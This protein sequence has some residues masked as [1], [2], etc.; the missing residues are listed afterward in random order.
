MRDRF[1]WFDVALWILAGLMLVP[2]LVETAQAVM[3][4]LEQVG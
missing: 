1:S 3:R 2:V 4:V